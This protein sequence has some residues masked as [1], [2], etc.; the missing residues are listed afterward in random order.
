[1]SSDHSKLPHQG[2]SQAVLAGQPIRQ[3]AYFVGD[4]R[5]AAARHAALYGSG[6]F[7]I[8][9]VPPLAAVHRGREV[10]FDH[11]P[12][13]GQW[14][15]MQVE[16]IQQNNG[17]T[18]IFHDL[19]PEGSGRTGLHHIALFV[20]DLERSVEAFSKAGHLE[21]MRLTNPRNNVTVVMM[22]TVS[23]YGHFVEF[24]E[25]VAALTELYDLVAAAA[26]GYDGSNPVREL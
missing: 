15:T 11:T 6:P 19:F 1:M 3:I 9:D 16:L 20:D 24:Y 2:I 18:S 10:I 13:F 5:A 21:A 14:G 25:P 7:F 17:G 12:A 4:V 22:D 26:V 23:L 8:L